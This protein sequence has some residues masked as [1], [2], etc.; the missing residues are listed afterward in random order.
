MTSAQI[1]PQQPVKVVL[2][3]PAGGGTDGITRIIMDPLS[4]V[5]GQSVIVDYKTGGNTIIGAQSVVSAKPDGYTLLATMDMTM[6]ILPAV[7]SKLPFEPLKDLMPV[8][9]LA[10]VPAL[11]VAHPKVPANS[12]KELIEYSKANP[13]KLNYGAAVLYGQLL[14]EQLKSVSGLSYTYV[15]YKGAGEAVQALIGGHLDFMMLDIATGLN[16]IKD[17][18]VK[19]LGITSPQRNPALPQVQTVG[20]IGYPSVE[21]SVWYG[22]FAPAG[23]SPQ[24]IDKLNAGV[25]QVLAEPAIRKRLADLG[26]ETTNATPAQITELIR[27][28]TVKWA[29]AAKDGNIK[30]D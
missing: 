5:L 29:K 2:P 22:L 7:Y 24:V 11:F 13:N 25:S 9:L 6:T 26:H 21:M 4:K 3:F 28:D 19:A 12:L 1:Y 20:E 10:H 30:L 23:T 17:G 27:K 15:P 16:F 8:A 18:K 14:G